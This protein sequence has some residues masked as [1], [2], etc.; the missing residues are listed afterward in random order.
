MFKD[1]FKGFRDF[2]V[3]GNVV[4][5]AVAVV[6]GAA[7][8]QIVTA[9]SKDII[10]P[11]IGILGGTPDFSSFKYTINGSE[12]LIGDFINAIISF[13][14]TASV[15]YFFIVVPMNRI[16]ARINKGKS[17]DPTE[18]SCPECLSLIPIKATKCK[19][20]TSVVKTEK[21]K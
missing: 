1:M 17:E 2:L 10:T 12:L 20:C 14:I 16:T 18:Q 13:L 19:F 6:I 15:I 4:D 21:K 8:S 5:L 7:F 3:R 9:L 11:S